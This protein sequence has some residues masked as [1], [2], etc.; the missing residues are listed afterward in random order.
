MAANQAA[1]K[2][3]PRLNPSQN[4]CR[5]DAGAASALDTAIGES[6]VISHKAAAKATTCNVPEAF[7]SPHGQAMLKACNTPAKASK[8]YRTTAG[9]RTPNRKATLTMRPARQA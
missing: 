4:R 2:H 9:S 8:T 1:A 5:A 3:H 6:A 7:F